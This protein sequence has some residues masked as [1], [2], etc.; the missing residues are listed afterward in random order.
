MVYLTGSV[1]FLLCDAGI[2]L[3]AGVFVITAQVAK[4]NAGWVPQPL[5]HPFSMMHSSH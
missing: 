4:D 3:G 2:I 1:M 5:I